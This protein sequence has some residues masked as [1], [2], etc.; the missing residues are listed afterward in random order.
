LVENRRPNDAEKGE[1]ITRPAGDDQMEGL[2]RPNLARTDSV[3]EV[4][5]SPINVWRDK[6]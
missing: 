2:D 1:D 5:S 3:G 4:A 6:G